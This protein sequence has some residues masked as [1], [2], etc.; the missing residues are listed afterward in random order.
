MDDS[1]YSPEGQGL[2]GGPG[3][4]RPRPHFDRQALE[5]L[6]SISDGFFALDQDLRVTFFN[7]AAEGLL[8]RP[9]SEV[10]GRQIFE[11][12]PEARGSVFEENY[13]QALRQ[14]QPLQFEAWFDQE[15]YQNWYAVRVY[16]NEG[17]LS[18][19]FQVTTEQ[20]RAQAQLDRFFELSSDLLSI[21]GL[22]GYFRRVNPA[23]TRALGFSQEELLAR[24]FIDLVH[25]EDRQATREQLARLDQGQSVLHFNNRYQTKDG[26]WR[27]LSWASSPSPGEGLI[28]AVAR[29]VTD[30][31]RAERELNASTRQ[32]QLILDTM[33]A[34]IWFKDRLNNFLRVNR[35]T[36]RMM[37]LPEEQIEGKNASEVFPAGLAEKYFQD[38]RQVMDSGQA[39]LGIEEQYTNAAGETRWVRTDKLPWRDEEGR[40]AG[41]LAFAVDITDSKL[42]RE[43]L[44]ESERRYRQLFREMS[45]GLALHEIICDGQGR[46]VDYR[47]LDANPAFE[48]LTGLKRADVLGRTVREVL[49]NT[50]EIWIARYGHVALSGQP[51]QF[52]SLSREVGKYFEV[53]AYCPKP[54]QFA[55]LFQDVSERVRAQEELK[56]QRNRLHTLMDIAGVMILALDTQGR[57]ILANKKCCQ[58]LGYR[59]DEVVGQD[60]FENFLPSAMRGRVREVLLKLVNGQME[61]AEFYE[62]PVLT[63]GGQERII[64]WRNAFFLDDDGRLS[65]VLSSGEDIT[66][67]RREE[68]ERQ[69]LDAQIQHAQKLE[70][71][72]VLAGGI[73]HDFNNLL[74]SMLGNA[75]LALLDLPPESPVRGRLSDLRDIA[76][77]ASELS[78]QMLAYS[79]KGSFLVE[80]LSLNRLVDEMAHLLRVSIAKNVVLK[81]N[82]HP[83]LPLVQADP[84]QLRQVVM[85][86]IINASEAIGERSGVVTLSTGVTQVDKRYLRDTFVNDELPEGFYV[87][88]EVSDTGHGM[89]QD[90]KLRIFDPF[91]TTK[92]TGR[93]LGLSAVLGIVRGHRGAIKVYSEPSRGTSFK[94]LLP[95]A[96]EQAELGGGGESPEPAASCAGGLV[97]VVDDEE[98]VR[99]MTRM[100]LERSGYTVISAADGREGVA[101]FREHHAQLRA[102]ILDMTMPHMN[103]EEAFGEIRRLDASVPVILA[104]G[105]N[106]QDATNRF[107]GKGLAGFLQKP[108]RLKDLR[109]MMTQALGKARP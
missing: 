102:V 46:P 60:W 21:A 65:G 34:T 97:L 73:A 20:H 3:Q 17:G 54:G 75:E 83:D 28:Y 55:A 68:R 16:P 33:P 86:L 77:R 13:R 22:D 58:V 29:D 79:G 44:A 4:A 42:A 49:P 67:R 72:G 85:N 40:V 107:S 63:K 6:H 10:L 50:E 53:T 32:M 35:A 59:E 99:T 61:L 36:A 27:W 48:R 74:V 9:A 23:F 108:F 51:E 94:V 24:P 103:G 70:S 47:F 56:R 14:R 100:M 43:A 19:F 37:G 30:Q 84:S 101:M 41:V 87:Y 82:F 5:L 57:V 71:L 93:G 88:L 104:S 92:F 95:C 69:R 78:A 96:Q 98:S 90:T 106:Q 25:P 26:G 15:P 18:V 105:Y 80:A 91:F 39:K 66:D 45:S 109:E 8:G 2:P 12:F 52:E 1:D 62:N 38:D 89:D 76:I 64:A 31:M 81:Y 7:R 11:A